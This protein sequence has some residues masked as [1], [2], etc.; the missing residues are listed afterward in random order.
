[1]VALP[2][3]ATGPIRVFGCSLSL[4]PSHKSL[5]Y[6]AMISYAALINFD[7]YNLQYLTKKNTQPSPTCPHLTL[8][9]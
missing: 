4:P 8:S 6:Q 2:L 9:M 1:M 7:H 3:G 5:I